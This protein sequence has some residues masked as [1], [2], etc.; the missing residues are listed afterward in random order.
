V[1]HYEHTRLALRPAYKAPV[2]LRHGSSQRDTLPPFTRLIG[3]LPGMSNLNH[4][5]VLKGF[6]S[7]TPSSPSS[8][9]SS[10][11]PTSRPTSLS[12]LS[13]ESV[14]MSSFREHRDSSS[15]ESSVSSDVGENGFLI[16]TPPTR[17]IEEIGL[18]GIR[19]ADTEIEDDEV[20]NEG[21]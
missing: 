1:T 10:P 6:L 18:K 13:N 2:P 9:S 11:P 15:S 21:D 3:P 4:R 5:P 17:V 16:L 12:G 14:P 7:L 20:L 8:S 19:E